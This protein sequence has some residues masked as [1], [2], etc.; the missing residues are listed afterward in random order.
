MIFVGNLPRDATLVELEK[1]LGR[2]NLRVR[3]SS[4][5]GERKDK[6]EYH[7][8]LVNTESD[9]V[10]QKLIGQ[11]DGLKLGDNNLVARRYIDREISGDWQ[12][13]NRRIKQLSLDFQDNL[14]DI[15]N[16]GR[17]AAK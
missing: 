16:W 3:C 7:C 11:I 1:I 14:A 12:G 6:S 13:E 5:R 4:H 9:L 15:N 10:G 8:I 17:S 2:E